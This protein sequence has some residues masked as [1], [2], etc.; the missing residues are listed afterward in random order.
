MIS[1]KPVSYLKLTTRLHY[2]CYGTKQSV[3][4][5][6]DETAL[7]YTITDSDEIKQNGQLLVVDEETALYLTV[8]IWKKTVST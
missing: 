5:V 7:K 3:L 4:E 2:T 6:E 1:N 8:K